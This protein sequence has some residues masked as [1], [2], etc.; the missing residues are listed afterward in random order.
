MPIDSDVLNYIIEE[1]GVAVIKLI[2]IVDINR[3]QVETTI[4]FYQDSKF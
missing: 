4:G 2:R 1:R 3:A